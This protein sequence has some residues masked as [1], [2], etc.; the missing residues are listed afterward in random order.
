MRLPRHILQQPTNPHLLATKEITKDFAASIEPL[1]L[2][3]FRFLIVDLPSFEHLAGSEWPAAL[4]IDASRS[5]IDTLFQT[6]AMFKHRNVHDLYTTQGKLA[7][8]LAFAHL[9]YFATKKE[10]DF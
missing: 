6:E 5:S 3:V 7:Q 10:F 4:L 8:T 2:Y 9:H 1:P